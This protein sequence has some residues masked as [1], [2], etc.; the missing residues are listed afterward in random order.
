M[1]P[2]RTFT[3]CE[4][5][6]SW[7][8][9]T[10]VA[11]AALHEHVEALLSND[12]FQSAIIASFSLPHPRRDS[13]VYHAI[14]S[15]TLAEVQHIVSLG[16]QNAF[17]AWYFEPKPPSEDGGDEEKSE[18]TPSR[19]KLRA[20]PPPPRPDIDAYLSIFDP[21]TS[22]PAALKTFLSNAKKG[23]LRAEIAG[24]L[25]S[26]RYLHPAL[27]SQLTIPKQNKSKNKSG[28][29]SNNNVPPN[30]YLSFLSWSCRNLEWAGPSPS[31]TLAGNRS[32]HVLPVLM[33][34]FGCACPSHEALS[35]LRSLAAGREVLD[36]GSGGGYWSFML[37]QYGVRAVP[38]DSAQSAWRASWV[39]DTVIADGAEW[40]RKRRR[41]K[42]KNNNNNKNNKSKNKTATDIDPDEAVLLLVY[43]I[44]GGAL[45]GG[46][47]GDFTRSMMDA[48][49]GDTLAVVGTQNHNGYTGFRGMSMDEY[50]ER[51]R[52]GEGWVK[53]VQIA[54]PSFPGKDEALFVFQRGA[55]AP[56]TSSCIGDTDEAGR[57][58][59]GSSGSSS[60]SRNRNK[61][62]T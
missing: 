22:T 1:P 26:K 13:Y 36:L 2:S 43:P 23:S 44:V 61:D 14:V 57:A 17:H 5:A 6:P 56:H 46:E 40:L 29:N 24:Y 28:S 20:L 39:S 34:H 60:S 42:N 52:A 53:V 12:D 38:V 48:Y 62:T 41:G 31:S 19:A 33:H 51:E 27:A 32:H 16:R 25:N 9:T 3:Y 15:V 4:G 11:D 10:Y 18:Q 47:E 37:R 45:A 8:P 21:A 49:V 30:H 54:L 59:N 50:V 55:R 35:I 7:N 58:D